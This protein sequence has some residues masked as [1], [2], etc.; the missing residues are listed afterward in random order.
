MFKPDK[1]NPIS[2][3]AFACTLAFQRLGFGLEQI[4]AG[5]DKSNNAF[6]TLHHGGEQYNVILGNVIDLP[7]PKYVGQWREAVKSL[8]QGSISTVDLE[9]T[10]QRSEI[11]KNLETMIRTLI[12]RG[13]LNPHVDVEEELKEE[14]ENGEGESEN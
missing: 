5:V 11:Q 13:F 1:M 6:V 7:H 10:F 8:I 3:E 2:K 4:G 9:E 12:V 14:K